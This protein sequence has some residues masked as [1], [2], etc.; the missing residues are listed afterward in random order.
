MRKKKLL[1]LVIAGTM[2]MAALTGCGSNS[3]EAAPESTTK[4][5]EA[6]TDAKTADTKTADASSTAAGFE[7]GATIGISL[8]WLGTQNWKE[9]E[10]MF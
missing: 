6:T 10:T 7:A 1:S 9:A 3:R 2:A 4:T 8:P 5:S